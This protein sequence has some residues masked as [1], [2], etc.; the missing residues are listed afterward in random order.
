MYKKRKPVFHKH[1]FTLPEVLISMTILLTFIAL[2]TQ[3]VFS[4]TETSNTQYIKAEL[5][6]DLRKAIERIEKEMTSARN[7]KMT[8][9]FWP[10][11][12]NEPDK[13]MFSSSGS[14]IVFEVPA[15]D[16]YGSQIFG[17]D[18]GEPVCDL[19]GIKMIDG[20]ELVYRKNLTTGALQRQKVKKLLISVLPETSKGSKRPVIKDQSIFSHYLPISNTGVYEAASDGSVPLDNS[21]KLFSY[22]TLDADG[23]TVEI[24]DPAQYIN[25]RT[26]KIVLVAEKSYGEQFFTSKREVEIRLRNSTN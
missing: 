14:E 9:T 17:E 20:D 21:V 16:Q 19:V 6:M 10:G 5:D 8:A 11:P 22:Y 15:H 23:N 26:I 2:I 1:G 7:V 25:A 18:N 12:A 4:F 3:L 13:Y 24:T